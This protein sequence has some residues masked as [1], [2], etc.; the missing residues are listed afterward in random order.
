MTTLEIVEGVTGF[1][2]PTPDEVWRCDQL[3]QSIVFEE[4]KDPRGLLPE[5]F[6]LKVSVA[7]EYA[8]GMLQQLGMSP[9]GVTQFYEFYTQRLSQ[10]MSGAIVSAPGHGVSLLKSRMQSYAQALHEQHPQDPHLNVAAC[11][12]RY[13]GCADD[14]QL[15]AFCL[16]TCK[17]LNRAF[18]NEITSL[19]RP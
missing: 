15:T 17:F 4:G 10:G 12:T 3:E 18:L 9:E 16:D 13:V 14:P 19:S 1:L 11:F 5:L 8:M 6:F 7:L 2:P